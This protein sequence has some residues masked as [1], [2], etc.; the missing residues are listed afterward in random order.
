MLVINNP[1]VSPSRTNAS[2]HL[3]QSNSKWLILVQAL[4]TVQRSHCC[5]TVSLTPQAMLLLRF[6]QFSTA[7]LGTFHPQTSAARLLQL[8][9]ISGFSRPVQFQRRF[10]RQSSAHR[11]QQ[12]LLLL[13]SI[14][15]FF[16]HGH[17]LA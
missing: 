2:A 9:S 15:L 8:V 5:S 13:V 6:T 3:P 12:L 4:P 11:K 10:V 1:F 17:A 7:Q 14:L 16:L